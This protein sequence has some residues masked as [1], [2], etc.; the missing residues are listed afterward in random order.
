MLVCTKQARSIRAL[1]SPRPATFIVGEMS[2]VRTRLDARNK[3]ARYAFVQQWFVVV[4]H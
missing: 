4:I 2:L 1:V 3:W